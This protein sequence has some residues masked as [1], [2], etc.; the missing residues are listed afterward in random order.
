MHWKLARNEF[1]TAAL[2][3]TQN[4]LGCY[5]QTLTVININTKPLYLSLPD[6][7]QK[8]KIHFEN[9]G[10]NILKYKI[11]QSQQPS[12]QNKFIFIRGKKKTPVSAA[13]GVQVHTQ[14]MK[15]C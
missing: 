11:S 3:Q 4:L 12:K 14:Q 15:N 2:L 6:I 7:S 13:K 9:K 8:H 10:M 1:L 5:P